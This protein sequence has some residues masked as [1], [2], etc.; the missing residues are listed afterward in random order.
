MAVIAA[1]TH[2]APDMSAFISFM[3]W[4]GLIEMPPLSN[5]TPLPI[6][7]TCLSAPPSGV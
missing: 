2:A 3:P 7:A 4:A 6:S 5:V 1:T